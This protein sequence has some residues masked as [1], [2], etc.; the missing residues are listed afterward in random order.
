MEDGRSSA[1][2]LRL[3]RLSHTRRTIVSHGTHYGHGSSRWC[4]LALAPAF[5]GATGTASGRVL[6]R[7]VRRGPDLRHGAC[8]R[9]ADPIPGAATTPM[10]T[11]CAARAV[12]TQ[13]TVLRF[14]EI[15]GEGTTLPGPRTAH[16]D[17]ALMRRFLQIELNKSRLKESGAACFTG[18]P[19]TRRD[20][21]ITSTAGSG[22][23]C[24]PGSPLLAPTQPRSW[25][26]FCFDPP[27][28]SHSAH[29]A[30]YDSRTRVLFNS[31]GLWL[32]SSPGARPHGPSA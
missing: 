17:D 31:A 25:N 14:P 19:R 13:R 9:T 23:V 20:L 7:R 16:L 8:E 28:R 22:R 3:G 26:G 4:P 27:E 29:D 2:P 15:V 24:C 30:D 1:P 21:L 32:E 10:E 12:T 11:E 6:P 18:L 5:R